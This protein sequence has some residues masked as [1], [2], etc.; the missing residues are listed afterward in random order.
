MR[1]FDF[2][3]VIQREDDGR[4][5]AYCP[6]LPGCYTQGDSEDETRTMI[7]DAIR[8]HIEDHVANNLPL[9]FD[10]HIDKIHVTL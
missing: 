7:Q 5:T 3:V 6:S 2:A 1:E 4:F 8:L 10:S 9:Q